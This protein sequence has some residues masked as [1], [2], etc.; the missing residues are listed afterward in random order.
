M[1]GLT[2]LE[3]LVALSIFTLLILAIFGVMDM[4]RASWFTGSTVVDVH[5]EIIKSFMTI[6]KEL[7]NTRPA[8]ISLT[9]G[10]SSASITFKIPQDIEDDGVVDDDVLDASGGIE[11][12]GDIT[13]AL[14]S[15]N[16]IT[17]T[18]SGVVSILAN[19]IVSLQFT[20]PVASVDIIQ[21]D[22]TARKTSVMKRQ[23]QETGQIIIKMRN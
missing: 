4:G 14:N 1:K 19:S 6:E 9:S 2:L 20:R 18:A 23:F 10:T 7:R 11:W 8:E 5:R 17:R 3:I 21:I 13:Y 22:I 16:Q 12:S 15:S